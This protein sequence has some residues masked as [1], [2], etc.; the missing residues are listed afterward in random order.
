MTEIAVV[1]GI[2]VVISVGMFAIGWAIGE[3]IARYGRS[4]G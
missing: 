4:Q 1:V 3:A 2:V